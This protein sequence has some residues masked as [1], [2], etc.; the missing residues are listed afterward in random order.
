[1]KKCSTLFYLV[2]NRSLISSQIVNI[3]TFNED[4]D[5]VL[6]G[7]F[8]NFELAVSPELVQKTLNR[9]KGI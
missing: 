5:E 6:N 8:A 7:F 2:D 3:D 4:F 1:M 9:I